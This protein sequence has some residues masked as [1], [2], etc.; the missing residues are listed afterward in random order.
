VRTFLVILLGAWTL[1]IVTGVV[2]W[3]GG[4]LILVP[5]LL[6]LAWQGWRKIAFIT[7]VVAVFWL[8]NIWGSEASKLPEPCYVTT[9]F[10]GQ[11]VERR[12]LTAT[13]ADYL[14]DNESCQVLVRTEAWRE[15]SIGKQVVVKGS[16]QLTG[17]VKLE[18]YAKW[19][20]RQGISA[21]IWQAEIE[22]AGGQEQNNWRSSLARSRELINS[23]IERVFP[24][25]AAGLMAAML[26]GE[27][28]GVAPA[29]EEQF[30]QTGVGHILAISGL[31]ISLL[32]GLMWGSLAV[33]PVSL[34]SR[35]MVLVA[36]L[37][38]YVLLVGAPLS[39]VRAGWFWTLAALFRSLG[40]HISWPATLILTLVALISTWPLVVYEVGFQLSVA[41]VGGISLG[42]FLWPVRSWLGRAV[43]VTL[44]ATL[45]T[46][47]IVAQVFGVISFVSLIA[48]LLVVPVV[49]VLMILGIVAVALSWFSLPLSWGVGLLVH[50]LFVWMRLVTASLAAIPGA[51]MEEVVLSAWWVAFYYL[52]LMILVF[53][54]LKMQGRSWREIWA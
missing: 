13:E 51:F 20:K 44:G 47:P 42:L 3:G 25:P 28:G 30:R 11:V 22:A 16:V 32:M 6:F 43:I 7:A 8:G 19:L 12:K 5:V 53:L 31:H 45:A 18:S 14:I 49:P 54:V 38:G 33:L 26:L 23:R 17:A 2:Q 15:V 34:R 27:R 4:G 29:V 48:N 21:R 24:E 46:W 52:M 9:P 41:A 37:W 1:G 10:S 40:W 35:S 50:G 39:A 36:S